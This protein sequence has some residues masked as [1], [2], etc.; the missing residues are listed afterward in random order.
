MW[1]VQRTQVSLVGGPATAFAPS[2]PAAIVNI[3][4]VNL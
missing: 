3:F 4:Q 1:A 2:F